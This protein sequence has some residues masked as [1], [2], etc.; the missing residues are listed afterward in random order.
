MPGEGVR[1][2]T[3][4]DGSEDLKSFRFTGHRA[5]KIQLGLATGLDTSQESLVSGKLEIKQTILVVFSVCIQKKTKQKW[6]L[7]L[8]FA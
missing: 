3:L 6:S 7:N 2:V 1:T 5:T 8:L 4:L